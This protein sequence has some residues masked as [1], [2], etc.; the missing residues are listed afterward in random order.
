MIHVEQSPAACSL[1]TPDL[2][3]TFEHVS[4]RWRHTVSVRHREEWLPILTSVEGTPDEHAPPSPALQD[5]RLEMIDD[6]TSEFQLMG[7]SGRHIYSAAV[8]FD[9]AADRIDFDLCLRTRQPSLPMDAHSIYRIGESVSQQS[10]D[11]VRER[12][13]VVAGGLRLAIAVVDIAGNPPEQRCR[14]GIDYSDRTIRVGCGV[15]EPLPPAG[16]RVRW[17]YQISLAGSA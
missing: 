10:I 1:C 2:R 12:V 13:L 9:G 4:D 5:L 3:L 6:Q 16:R 7:Q 14:V 8:R 15:V 11:E 17:R